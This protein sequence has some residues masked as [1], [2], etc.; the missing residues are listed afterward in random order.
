MSRSQPNTQIKNPCERWF[1]W[2]GE[3]SKGY[4]SWYEKETKQTHP[5]DQ[6]FTFL[7]LD[8]LNT[9]TG[10]DNDLQESYYANEIRNLKTETL[11]IRSKAGVKASGLYEHIKTQSKNFNFTKSVYIAFYDED[12][13]LKIGNIKFRGA[14]LSGLSENAIKANYDEAVVEAKVKAKT[15]KLN[16]VDVPI[17][18]YSPAFLNSIGWINFAN[19]NNVNKI[20]VKW[21]D[22][23]ADVNGSIK[24]LRPVFQAVTNISEITN[25][26]AIELDKELQ[27]YLDWYFSQTVTTEVVNGAVDTPTH[28]GQNDDFCTDAQMQLLFKLANKT[29]NLEYDLCVSQTDGQI[30][31]FDGLSKQDASEIISF[32]NENIDGEMP[33][34]FSGGN[35]SDDTVPF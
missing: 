6:P 28:S 4:F 9:I 7:V 10:Y 18:S 14:G 13:N 21:V 31:S 25:F 17:E 27:V 34:E 26:Q 11:T 20:A 35:G 29:G 33:P 22:T 2:E 8:Q 3:A 16:P 32:L 19:N 15:E 12:K 1:K 23:I 30:T 5:V 24:F